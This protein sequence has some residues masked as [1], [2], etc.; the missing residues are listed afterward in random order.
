MKGNRLL[1]FIQAA[2]L[3]LM[4]SLGAVGS[5]I[6]GFRLTIENMTALVLALLAFALLCAGAFRL[7]YGGTLVM[8][9]L[10]L[11]SGWLWRR[12]EAGVQILQL[13][14]R[15]TH[16][17]NKAYGWGV[18]KLVDTAWNEGCADL[19]MGIIGAVL[20][21]AVS[22]T[23]SR[24]R[25]CVPAVLLSL[26]PLFSCLVVTDT[27]PKE[28]YLYLLI[29]GLILLILTSRVRKNNAVQGN[30]LVLLAALPA[31]AALGLLFLAVPQKDYV[32]QS[33]EFREN[34][35]AWFQE[36]PQSLEQTVQQITVPAAS[37]EPEDVDLAG[38]GRRLESP[39]TVM[40]VTADAG[41]T[42]YL[43]G[44]DYDGYNGTGWTA[45][46]HRSESFGYEGV[47]LGDVTIVTRR[48]MEQLY[49]PYYPSGGMTLTG[50]AMENTWKYREYVIGRTG[51]PDGW[52]A[53]PDQSS[54]EDGISDL[55]LSTEAAES[56]QDRL[57]YLTLPN[58]AALR[59]KELLDTILTDAVG[60]TEQA[61]A[62]GD[63]VRSCAE[64]DLNPSRMPDTE[65][66]FALWFLEEAEKGYCVH[67]ATAAVVLLRAAGIEARYVGG[68]MVK[69]RA[70]ETA[71]VT[72]ENA[73]AWA[74]YYVPSLDAWV[75]LEATPADASAMQEP[76]AETAEQTAPITETETTAPSQPSA[77]VPSEPEAPAETTAVSRETGDLRWLAS[78]GKA[79]L[80]GAVL[81]GILTGQRQVR[82]RLRRQ[83][84]HRGKPNTQAL[85]RWQ[86]AE[87]LSRLLK[88]PPPQELEQLAQKAKFSQ[89]T[90]TAEELT[91]FE[92][93]F[94]TARTEL[95][96]KPWYV[97]AV[98]QYLYAAY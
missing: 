4:I 54:G 34:I 81:L 13:V 55:L 16:V 70:G 80:A 33:K 45:A 63:Y 36:V 6:T 65:E 94:R 89:H 71:I 75:V 73:H 87:L 93:Y 46:K 40:E 21:L 42:L 84:Q 25:G 72:G 44:Q 96:Q 50:G 52:Q 11:L 78:L 3:A 68:Y 62:I 91:R 90:L 27:V 7:K 95:Q 79:L 26:L 67:F 29:L 28:G 2:V 48:E 9:L 57:R 98:H 74:E 49:L 47:D 77:E 51:L 35:L 14:Y 18:F 12:G 83:R 92:T 1:T 19:P 60:I 38:L 56:T 85:A 30:R 88:Q 39:A 10:A 66:D 58:A 32:N 64:Y 20:I 41:G 23:V 8:C 37:E 43:R 61:T 82:L 31:A 69:V 5:M 86:E 17:Y 76:P 97:R 15:I 24:R 22:W 53:Q 59:A